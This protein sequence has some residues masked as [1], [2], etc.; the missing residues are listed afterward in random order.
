VEPV[1]EILV[2][3]CADPHALFIAVSVTT[4]T[5]AFAA[6]YNAVNEP[7]LVPDDGEIVL[8]RDDDKVHEEAFATESESMAPDPCCTEL[9][10][11]IDADTAGATVNTTT[12]S[13]P[14]PQAFPA[15][16]E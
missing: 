9:G 7:V 10:P 5:P 11:D 2:T 13:S 1:T 16:P 6:M 4:S 3:R 8:P 12:A 14:V 15:R